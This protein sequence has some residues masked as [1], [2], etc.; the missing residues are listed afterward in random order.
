MG[1]VGVA[2][3]SVRRQRRRGTLTD[4]QKKSYRFNRECVGR[5]EVELEVEGWIGEAVEVPRWW[6]RL[7]R[8]RKE[9]SPFEG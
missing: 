7:E 4:E 5:E 1:V 9:V 8:E 6:G 3:V 2:E